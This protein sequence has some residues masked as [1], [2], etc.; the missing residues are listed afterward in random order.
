MKIYIVHW[1]SYRRLDFSDGPFF[2]RDMTDVKAVCSTLGRA[3]KVMKRKLTNHRHRAKVSISAIINQGPN[4]AL[5]PVKEGYVG[6]F[7]SCH[8]VDADGTYTPE[9]RLRKYGR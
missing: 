6:Y 3:K 1:A 7:I 8:T 4:E 2:S 9:G 5:F